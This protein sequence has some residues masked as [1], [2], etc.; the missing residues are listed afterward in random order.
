MA[1]TAT[2]SIA[3]LSTAA[4]NRD[5]SLANRD[6]SGAFTDVNVI[7][8]TILGAGSSGILFDGGVNS[9]V[10]GGE[11]AHVGCKGVSMSGPDM[12]GER[13]EWIDGNAIQNVYI[14]DWSE[15]VCL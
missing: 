8:C 13:T 3:S 11:V 10:S 14:H 5:T 2:D 4:R 1:T 7:N 6:G 9:T 12:P 15:T